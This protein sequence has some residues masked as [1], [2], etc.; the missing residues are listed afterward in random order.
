MTPVNAAA[1][2]GESL[3]V[4]FWGAVDA[5]ELSELPHAASARSVVTVAMTRPTVTARR[6]DPGA[7][8]DR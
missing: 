3:P 8:P 1:S 5:G 2:G 7:M 4:V 6:L